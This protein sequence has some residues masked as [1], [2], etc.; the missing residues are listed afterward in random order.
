MRRCGRS[1]RFCCGPTAYSKVL[2]DCNSRTLTYDD[3]A[4]C[5][6]QRCLPLEL[7]VRGTVVSNDNTS[8][9]IANVAVSFLGGTVA[10]TDDN[11]LFNFTV[12]EEL[13]RITLTVT[14]SAASAFLGVTKTLSIAKG[15]RGVVTTTIKLLS[16]APAQMIEDPTAPASLVVTSTGGVAMGTIDFPA[17][18]IYRASGELVTVSLSNCLAAQYYSS[19]L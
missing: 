12:T 4:T 1:E 5:G 6:C 13:E 15:R 18:A 19:P 11:G 3:I 8:E 14:P 10:T 17:N 9:P 7:Y 16:K 2:V